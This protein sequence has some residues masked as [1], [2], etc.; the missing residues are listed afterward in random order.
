MKLAPLPIRRDEDSHTYFWEPTGE[1]LAYSTTQV[2][3]IEKS[4]E[5]LEA[6]E[7]TRETWEPRGKHVHFCLEQYLKGEIIPDSNEYEE[8]VVP[9]LEHPFWTEFEPW[10]VEYM[11]CDLKKSVGGQL[12]VLGYD[13]K[14]KQL[15]LVDLKTQG[16]IKSS[17]YNTDAQLGSYLHALIDHLKINVDICRTIWSRPGKTILGPEQNVD[18]CGKAWLDAWDK[19]KVFKE[20]NL[21]EIE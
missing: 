6:I 2:T 16:S 21:T 17:K 13:H 14:N 8:W 10:A 11:V 15:V 19:F 20:L 7:R 1:Q 12:D 4:K 5:A 18:N 9:L 3:G